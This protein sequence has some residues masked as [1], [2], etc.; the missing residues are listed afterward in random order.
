MKNLK[1]PGSP[2]KAFG[3]DIVQAFGD[4]R[5]MSFPRKRESRIVNI[6]KMT[7]L[8]LLFFYQP[9]FADSSSANYALAE[10]RFTGGGG[11]ASSSNYQVAETSFDAFSGLGL[12]STNYALDT[13][14]GISGGADIATINSVTPSDFA[15]FYSDQSAS[16]VVNAV[17][18]DGD[19]LQY[20]A[21]QDSTVKVGP[22]SSATLSW[23]L[24]SSDIGRH[25]ISLEVIDPQ[26]TTLKKQEVYVVRSPTK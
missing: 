17:S 6:L 8:G 22:Q 12:T 16:Y 20:R 19:A 21:T 14:S 5:Q 1:V 3:D 25:T 11:S 15:K 9:A 7:I 23:A 10:D 4:D 26:G 18:Q 13:K 2:I 24:T